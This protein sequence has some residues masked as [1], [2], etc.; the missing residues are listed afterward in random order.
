M[1]G[2]GGG[3]G[4]GGIETMVDEDCRRG[5]G[6]DFLFGSIRSV[7]LSTPRF[8]VEFDGKVRLPFDVVNVEA[9]RRFR[10][11]LAFFGRTGN[12][13]VRVA[14]APK[15]PFSSI[16][17]NFCRLRCSMMITQTR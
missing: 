11:E 1:A 6:S 9:G 7:G 3:R 5:N 12:C 14:T 15:V 16:R 4:G 2:R 8:A 17:I 10:P 13:W